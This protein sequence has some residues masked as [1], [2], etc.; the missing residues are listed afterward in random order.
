MNLVPHTITILAIFLII[1]SWGFSL[2]FLR[3]V[4]KKYG[5][6]LSKRE[7]NGIAIL[8]ILLVLA[9][10]GTYIVTKGRFQ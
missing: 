3:P 6:K 8:L 10:L 4:V 2:M 1:I 9:F 7:L 5:I